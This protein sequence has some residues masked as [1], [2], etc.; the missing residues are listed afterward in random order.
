MQQ[1]HR[2]ARI[3]GVLSRGIH[4]LITRNIGAVRWLPRE[5]IDGCGRTAQLTTLMLMNS[6]HGG[7][8]SPPPS[9]TFISTVSRSSG[10]GFRLASQSETMTA[11]HVPMADA[12]CAQS[13]TYFHNVCWSA[14]LVLLVLLQRD[15]ESTGKKNRDQRS[16]FFVAASVP[17]GIGLSACSTC[18]CHPV[19]LR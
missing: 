8:V 10:L 9:R 11:P 15:V 16:L 4:V 5:A 13:T 12:I 17:I 14:I 3:L 18:V 2:Q 19:T 6:G 1:R 7:P